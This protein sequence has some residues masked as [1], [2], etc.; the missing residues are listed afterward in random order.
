[1]FEIH[2]FFLAP[3]YL[4]AGKIKRI[5][6][7]KNDVLF[8]PSEYLEKSLNEFGHIL[9]R[10]LPTSRETKTVVA[11]KLAFIHNELNILHSFREG[12]GR[13][14][15]LFLDPLATHVGYKPI[16]WEVVSHQV[17]IQACQMGMASE[18]DPMKKIVY[19]G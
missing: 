19:K 15:R 6:I 9:T 7:S 14:I 3:L 11:Q 12:N 4:W 18:H 8:A 16:D 10:H 1:M 17:Y 13:T 5:N 2:T